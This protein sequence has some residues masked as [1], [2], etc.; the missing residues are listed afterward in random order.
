VSTS[1]GPTLLISWTKASAALR[2]FRTMI[3]QGMTNYY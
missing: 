2:G 3:E 1:P